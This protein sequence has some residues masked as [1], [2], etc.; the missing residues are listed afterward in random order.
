[1]SR[2]GLATTRPHLNL[3]LFSGCDAY[4]DQKLNMALARYAKRKKRAAPFITLVSAALMVLPGSL[5]GGT[6]NSGLTLRPSLRRVG[7][8]P[9]PWAPA[10]IPRPTARPFASLLPRL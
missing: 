10:P 8:A 5:D 6:S 1:M 2:C 7:E 3:D 9:G 4:V